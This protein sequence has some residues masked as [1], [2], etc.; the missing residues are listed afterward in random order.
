MTPEGLNR[1][2]K[3]YTQP[4]KTGRAGR[5]RPQTARSTENS[6]TVLGGIPATTA[7]VAPAV[8]V[9]KAADKACPPAQD[10]HDNKQ[11]SVGCEGIEG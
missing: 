11:N 10:P 9:Q 2:V 7:A 4:K 6:V 8:H 1:E 3:G 5:S